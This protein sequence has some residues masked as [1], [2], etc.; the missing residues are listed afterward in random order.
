MGASVPHVCQVVTQHRH[1]TAIIL[2]TAMVGEEE[3]SCFQTN[4]V[5]FTS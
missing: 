2:L 4:L 5:L 1:L 3:P